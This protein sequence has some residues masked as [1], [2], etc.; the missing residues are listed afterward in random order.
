MHRKLTVVDGHIAFVGGINIIDDSNTPH[1]IPPR[2]DYA[3]RIEGPL[4]R[5]VRAAQE[6]LWRI[7]CW[8]NFHRRPT[9]PQSR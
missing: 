8:A 3:I 2:F 9:R 7:L 4:V 5:S 6:N 1:Q